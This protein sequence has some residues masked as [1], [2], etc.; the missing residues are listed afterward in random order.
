MKEPKLYIPTRDEFHR[1]YAGVINE[2]DFYTDYPPMKAYH[3]SKVASSLTSHKRLRFRKW[4]KKN[5]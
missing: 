1:E 5:V 4:R 3:S 2:Y